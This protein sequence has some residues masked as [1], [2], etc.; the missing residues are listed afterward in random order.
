MTQRPQ[1]IMVVFGTRPEAIKLAPVI[2][3]LQADSDQFVVRICATAQHRDMLDQVLET[4]GIAPHYDLQVMEQG[5]DL[6]QVI[7][8]CLERLQSVLKKE[9]PAWVLIQGDTTSAFA[10]ALAAAYL[11]IPVAHVEAGLRTG[12]PA[13]PFPE[14]TNRQLITQLSQLHFAPT[15]G[16]RENLLREG[17]CKSR[18]HVT[19]NT[20]IDA[21]FYACERI[22]LPSPAGGGTGN[23]SRPLIL[24]TSHRRESFG[25]PLRQICL[26]VRHI[27]LQGKADVIYLVHWNPNVREPVQRLLGDLPNVTLSDPVDY[28]SFIALMQRSYLILTDS[29][30]IQEECPSLGKPVLVLREFTERVESVQSCN[31]KLVGTNPE[32]ILAETTRLLEDREEYARRSRARNLYGDGQASLRIAQILA[33][34]QG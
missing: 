9:Q 14:E 17:V 21:L 27:A 33:S 22:G 8:R 7:R 15:S 29:G 11:Q 20:G 23:G 31:A 24:V 32:K 12:N 10:A 2:R 30:G 13:H 19:G 5:Q 16:A 4:F 26:G 18:I 34:Q 1:K 25:E 28:I 3:A 6:F